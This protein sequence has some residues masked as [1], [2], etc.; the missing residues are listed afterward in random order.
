MLLGCRAHKRGAVV[1]WLARPRGTPPFGVRSPAQTSNVMFKCKNLARYI[2]DCVS[3][4][5]SDDTLKSVGL[6]YLVSMPGEV[7][8]PHM[9]YMCNLSWTPQ[10]QL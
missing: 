4:C 3:V 9:G 5:L 1:L 6:F 7:K 2:R 8:N 10:F